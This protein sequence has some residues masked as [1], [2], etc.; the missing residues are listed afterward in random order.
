MILNSPPPGNYI[1]FQTNEHIAKK[2]VFLNG[3]EEG[4]VW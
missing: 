1:Y 3:I 2:P 4:F